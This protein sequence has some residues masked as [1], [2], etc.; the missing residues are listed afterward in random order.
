METD[1]NDI[2]DEQVEDNSGFGANIF[3]SLD[4]A[5]QEI[6]EKIAKDVLKEAKENASDPTKW[7]IS[8]SITD[9]SIVDCPRILESLSEQLNEYGLMVHVGQHDFIAVDVID[10]SLQEEEEWKDIPDAPSVA[11]LSKTYF[12]AKTVE[13]F[14][15]YANKIYDTAMG[16]ENTIKINTTKPPINGD[17]RVVKRIL[18][19]LIFKGYNVVTDA[20]ED[21]TDYHKKVKIITISW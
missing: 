13:A 17:P 11:T 19:K 10:E 16:G 14:D 1:T 2:L 3:K 20:S 6:A 7:P 5:A 9:S 12:N 8:V 15:F 18:K 4:I 21:T